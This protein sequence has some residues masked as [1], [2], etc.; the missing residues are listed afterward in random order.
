MPKGIKKR[1]GLN[2]SQSIRDFCTRHP[3]QTAKQV[4]DG[5][6]LQGIEVTMQ[7]VY[8]VMSTMRAG[9]TNTASNGAPTTPIVAGTPEVQH[10]IDAFVGLQSAVKAIVDNPEQT[11]IERPAPASLADAREM[12]T[13]L[14]YTV[15]DMAQLCHQNRQKIARLEPLALRFVQS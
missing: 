5:L 4:K 1:Q 7:S 9:K 15:R 12:L 6:A 3:D 8:S 11:V 13:M 2:K 14:L 10:T